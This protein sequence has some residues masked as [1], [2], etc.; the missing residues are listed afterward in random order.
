MLPALGKAVKDSRPVIDGIE[1][2]SFSIGSDSGWVDPPRQFLWG[3]PPVQQPFDPSTI[4]MPF[5]VG[6]LRQARER[7]LLNARHE[8]EN[9]MQKKMQEYSTRVD[10]QVREFIE[11]V[12]QT[13][14][15]Y[16]L[17]THFEDLAVR[18]HDQRRF[19]NLIITD[20]LFDCTPTVRSNLSGLPEGRVIVLM[21]PTAHENPKM[22][23]DARFRVREQD[24]IRLFRSATIMRPYNIESLPALLENDSPT[25][26][27]KPDL[28]AHIGGTQSNR[29][30]DIM[31]PVTGAQ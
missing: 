4:K 16:S 23:E 18:M 8:H 25:R 31:H 21:S 22:S 2:I 13:P 15:S 10:K 12:A 19:L 24:M 11:W 1:G 5:E 20:G 30:D 14:K 7:F 27:E 6:F 28:A 26:S 17:C 3:P 9:Q 29:S